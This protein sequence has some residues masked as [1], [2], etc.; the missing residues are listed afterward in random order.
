ME[1]LGKTNSVGSCGES[2]ILPL[3]LDA[4]LRGTAAIARV[5]VIVRGC[6][7]VRTNRNESLSIRIDP[8]T[9]KRLD[10]I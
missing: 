1:E 6:V 2:L 7:Q 5:H 9:K 10:A 4:F 8:K 3:T